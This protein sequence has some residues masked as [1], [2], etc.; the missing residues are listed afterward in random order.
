MPE[1]SEKDCYG[2]DARALQ[3]SEN[4]YK[5][6]SGEDMSLYEGISLGKMVE[7]KLMKYFVALFAGRSC[8]E[9]VEGQ[10][11]KCPRD[12]LKSFFWHLLVFMGRIGAAGKKNNSKKTILIEGYG[13][14]IPL[15]KKL[16]REGNRVIVLGRLGFGK[17]LFHPNIFYY[18]WSKFKSMSLQAPMSFHDLIGESTFKSF[19]ASALIKKKLDEVIHQ[20]FPLIAAS[21]FKIKKFLTAQK[22]D[23]IITLQDREGINRILTACGNSLGL[24]TIEIQ[25][26]TLANLPYLVSP[27]SEKICVWGKASK[28][29]YLKR[30]IDEKRIYIVGEPNLERLTRAGKAASSRTANLKPT[31]LFA[32]Q[33]FIDIT[34]LDSPPNTLDLFKCLCETARNLPEIEFLIKFHP[35]ENSKIKR[36]ILKGYRSGNVSVA[37]RGLTN[38]LLSSSHALI[39]FSSSIVLEASLMEVPVII[40]NLTGKRDFV[41]IADMGGAIGVYQKKDLIPAIKSVLYDEAVKKKLIKGQKRF[42]ESYIDLGE[43]SL[44]RLIEVI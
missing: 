30:K 10:S 36:E 13:K 37:E 26:G 14:F 2:I 32:S 44:K 41:P 39:T 31:V 12:I 28:E 1:I 27:I 38:E 16:A 23:T 42:V 6:E 25:H 43:P 35:N 34:S 17:G 22:V 3:A 24:D 19:N 40:V 21:I 4:W 20:D 33:P 5:K 29:F 7:Y 8:P 18:S 11:N 9:S 15:I